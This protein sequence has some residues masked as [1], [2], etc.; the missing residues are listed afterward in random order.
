MGVGQKRCLPERLERAPIVER[1]DGG[2]LNHASRTGT[3]VYVIEIEQFSR[4]KGQKMQSSGANRFNLFKQPG[5]SYYSV[6]LMVNG[7]R[8]RFSTGESGLKA[9]KSKAAAIMADIKSRGFDDAIKLHST[10]RDVIPLDPTFGEFADLYRTVIATADS[11]P[12]PTTSERYLRSLERVCLTSGVNRMLK[13]DAAAVE[14]F[15]DAYIR[16]ALPDSQPP[17]KRSAPAK[18]TPKRKVGAKRPRD[19]ASVRTTLNGILRNAAAIF[20]KQLLA[21]YALRG[22][23]LENPFAGSKLRRVEIKAHSPFPLD[24]IERIWT[25]A[26]LLRDGNPDAPPPVEGVSRRAAQAMDFRVPRPDAYAI[27]LLEMG[28]GLRRNEADKAEWSWVVEMG[29][30]RRFLEVRASDGFVP[31]SKKSRII[32]MDPFIWESLAAIKRDER[33]IV[34]GPGPKT[35]RVVRAKSALYRCEDAHRTLVVWLRN[36]GVADPKPCHA[37]RKQFGSYVATSFSLFHAQKLLGHS[38]PAVTAAYYAS[39]TDLPD[40]EPSRMGRK[41]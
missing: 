4:M 20:S 26:P 6:R 30:G 5:S 32:P 28:L 18:A 21:A 12:S 11:P 2:L 37:L 7:Q 36:C 15:K 31:K 38:T 40:L 8:R 23:H 41:S 24:L 3:N 13:L 35:K 39:L 34:P 1:A 9:A 33:F 14:R 22:L 16:T 27:L 17:A 19:A 10:R 29:D 25:S